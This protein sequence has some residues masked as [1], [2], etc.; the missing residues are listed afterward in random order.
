MCYTLKR[1]PSRIMSTGG[2]R[3]GGVG[4]SSVCTVHIWDCCCRILLRLSSSSSRCCVTEAATRAYP[5]FMPKETRSTSFISDLSSYY[6][7]LFQPELNVRRG[8]NLL[9]HH[10]FSESNL[11]S[12]LE[13]VESVNVESDLS[14]YIRTGKLASSP[15]PRLFTAVVNSFSSSS[16]SRQQ[17]LDRR[18]AK[19]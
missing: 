8:A 4:C 1:P 2:I 16:S 18:K 11:L 5:L 14:V 12:R 10:L 6:R 13:K 17:Q 3:K 9:C 19:K 15:P 7:I